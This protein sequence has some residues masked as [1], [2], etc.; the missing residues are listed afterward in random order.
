MIPLGGRS[1][2]QFGFLAILEVHAEQSNI[3]LTQSNLGYVFAVAAFVGVTYDWESSALTF[4]QEV[5][6]VWRQRWSLMSFLYLGARYLGIF[7]AA[8]N[9]LRYRHSSD[10]LADRY[11]GILY[12]VQ[13]WIGVFVFAMLWVIM[14][15]RL[16]AMYQ[17]SRRILIFLIVT[18]LA[19]NAFDGVAAMIFV[20]HI[21]GKEY[22]L[23][24]T[25]M[26]QTSFAQEVLLLDSIAWILATV[27]EVLALCLAV[28]IAVKH[29][30]ELRRHSTGGIIG[31]FF[32][33]LIKTHMA[34]FA[35][36]VAVSCF[37][38]VVDLSPAI[39]TNAD[40]LESQTFYGL[41]QI[42]TV[43]QA[44]VL[45]PRLILGI[46]EYH[47]KLVANA[48]AASGMT[49]IA[50]QERVHISTSSSV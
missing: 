37:T 23:S 29:F 10:H 42:S 40:S 34:Y 45:G 36:F 28:W 2:M 8:L 44:F 11:S 6:L 3:K 38:F 26:C 47:A 27:W 17:G 21:S 32:S 4:G 14:I 7:Y 25:Y 48:D 15:T 13:D 41:L 1:S 33:V 12:F 20:T 31:D 22:I 30:R 18:F 9:M 35:S 46:R 49:S 43:V 5:E 16:Y 50:F 24:D 19:I 39:S